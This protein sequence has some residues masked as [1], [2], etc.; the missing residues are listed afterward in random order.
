MF[1]GSPP[2]REF[3]KPCGAYN[4]TEVRVLV[5]ARIHNEVAPRTSRLS[6]SRHCTD[7]HS[8]SDILKRSLT[9]SDLAKCRVIPPQKVELGVLR[10]V[11]RYLGH[12]YR[13]SKWA[14]QGVI[15]KEGS[16]EAGLP[17]VQWSSEHQSFALLTKHHYCSRY[18]R[19]EHRTKV[20]RLARDGA[21]QGAVRDSGA[22]ETRHTVAASKRHNLR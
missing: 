17:W 1:G 4:Y 10:K 22:P 15:T 18:D 11:E 13:D 2:V 3:E 8:I 14:F 21:G 20:V 19:C 5:I 9:W 6:L 16:E 7:G 12:W